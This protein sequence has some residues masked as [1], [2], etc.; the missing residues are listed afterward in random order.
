[1]VSFHRSAQ[2]AAD[3]SDSEAVTTGP[4]RANGAA[5]PRVNLMPEV[6]A[7]EARAHRAKVV[8]VG[9]AVASLAVVGGLY[10]VAAATVSSAQ[11]RL[12]SAQAQAASLAT[13]EAKYADVPKVQAEVA[14]AS[15]QQYQALGGE[16]RW[17]FLLNDLALTIPSGTSLT[18][19]AGTITGV[20]PSASVASP[21]TSPSSAPS[22]TVVSVLG[23]PGIGT[24]T[25][26]GEALG[27]PQVAS[28]LDSQAKQKTLLDPFVTSAA[29]QNDATKKG[30]TFSSTATITAA[31]LSHRY[32]P[33]AGS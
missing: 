29:T 19:F 9:A 2:V 22:G 3:Q 6:V 18:S 16:V 5:F 7:A 10:V 14:S 17:S 8:A 27:Y 26:Q 4:A 28:F 25:Y 33:K 12:D 31:A 30:L 23:H 32:D 20:P 13:E 24:I 1:M 15:T 11:D 21:P